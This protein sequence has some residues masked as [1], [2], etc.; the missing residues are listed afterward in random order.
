V[1][2]YFSFFSS[3]CSTESTCSWLYNYST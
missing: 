1:L 2:S 3:G